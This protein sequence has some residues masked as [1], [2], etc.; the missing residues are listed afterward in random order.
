[1]SHNRAFSPK[2]ILDISHDHQV[3]HHQM[4]PTPMGY[5]DTVVPQPIKLEIM[6]YGGDNAH[7]P[8]FPDKENNY[9]PL[10]NTD[11]SS[12][13][14]PYGRSENHE[15]SLP[16]ILPQLPTRKRR[17]SFG[18]D[19][20]ECENPEGGIGYKSKRP[21]F[22]DPVPHFLDNAYEPR[23]FPHI[24]YYQTDIPIPIKALLDQEKPTTVPPF[25]L[26]V[27]FDIDDDG[28]DI[29]STDSK[30]SLCGSGSSM[31]K[32]VKKPKRRRKSPAKVSVEELH[33]QRKMANV[34]E[35]QRTQNLNEAYTSLRKI[36]PTMPSDKLSKIE[37]LKLAAKYIE[38][39]FMIL[40]NKEICLQTLEERI[41]QSSSATGQTPE[42]LK[43][44]LNGSD[45]STTGAIAQEKLSLMFSVWRMD[46]K[47]NQGK[48]SPD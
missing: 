32:R 25:D 27:N 3:H 44:I 9:M 36:I 17:E 1:M 6:D 28:D 11:H 13:E 18:E 2:V 12:C 4:P 5:M 23:Y 37:T 14:Y 7:V 45:V 43:N 46:C 29:K 39:L 33:D 41:R 19:H 35:R 30:V 10:F 48:S 34:R 16:T 24:D 21:R 8:P 22:E 20:F 15:L 31:G 47:W 38:F 42:G 40:S 26:P